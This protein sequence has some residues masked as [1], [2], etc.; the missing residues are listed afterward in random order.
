MLIAL[1]SLITGRCD[2]YVF[3]HNS[4][5]VMQLPQP[6]CIELD[7]RNIHGR[8]QEAQVGVTKQ[9]VARCYTLQ[10]LSLFTVYS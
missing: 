5:S 4:S 2:S 7:E 1:H 8:Q 3:T 6:V 10:L 9:R